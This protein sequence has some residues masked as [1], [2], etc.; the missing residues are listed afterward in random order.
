[1]A[2]RF[3]K[4]ELIPTIALI[5]TVALMMK[6]GFWQLDRLHWKLDLLATIEKAQSEAPRDFVSFSEEELPKSEWHNVIVTGTL[7]ND[8][9]L[10]AMPRYLHDEMGYAIFTPL[11][12]ATPAGDEYVLVNRGWVKPALKD[13]E[14]RA[15]SNPAAPVRVE[16]VIRLPHPRKWP[17]PDNDP[18]KNIWFWYDLPAMAEHT[19]LKLLPVMIDA[20]KLTLADGTQIKDGPSPFPLEVSIRNDHLGYAFTWFLLGLCAVGVYAAYYLE[21]TDRK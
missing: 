3:R 14:S 15:Q 6:L 18:Q 8:K 5:I 21:K 2:Y 12:V 11:K 7:V 1:M 20:T 16:G 19:G 17:Q 4:P 9:E 13:A 10:H